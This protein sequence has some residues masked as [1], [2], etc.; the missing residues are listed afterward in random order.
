MKFQGDMMDKYSGFKKI[1]EYL[2]DHKNLNN[3]LCE[4]VFIYFFF[5]LF[6]VTR[7]IK[8]GKLALIFSN[9]W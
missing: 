7:R 2:S 8:V 5:I 9:R 3:V 4:A 1:G 6:F